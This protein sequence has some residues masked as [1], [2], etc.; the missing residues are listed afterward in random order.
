MHRAK[1]S[2]LSRSPQQ[3]FGRGV[4]GNSFYSSK[5]PPGRTVALHYS[6]GFVGFRHQALVC[7]RYAV[8]SLMVRAWLLLWVCLRLCGTLCS[9]AV[10]PSSAQRHIHCDTPPPYLLR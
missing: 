9:L 5:R 6:D 3:P 1:S 7:Q 4:V 2:S 8:L 10:S